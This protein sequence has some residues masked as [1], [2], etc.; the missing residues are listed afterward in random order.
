MMA[1]TPEAG[2]TRLLVAT[3]NP[4]KVREIEQVLRPLGFEVVGLHQLERD[5]PEPVEDA[6]TFE[7]NARIKALAYAQALGTACL[8]EDSGLEVDALGG[9]PGVHS[10]RY[11]G[12]GS[13]REEKDR[14]NNEKLLRALEG[15]GAGSRRARFVCAMCLVDARGNI[16]FE[17]RGTYEGVIAEAARGDGGFGYDPLLF[18]PDLQKTS[19][20]LTPAE[21]NARSHRGHATRALAAFLRARSREQGA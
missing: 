10:A 4:N 14:A 21:K 1:M 12:L 9:A 15:H 6:D 20:E 13:T 16:E 19:A 18:L 7:G 11:A 5:L 8:A 3:T 2:M 17:T